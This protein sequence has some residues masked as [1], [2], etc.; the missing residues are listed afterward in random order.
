MYG[1]YLN[2][3][4]TLPSNNFRQIWPQD[5]HGRPGPEFQAVSRTTLGDGAGLPSR[6]GVCGVAPGLVG[7]GV[8]GHTAV[9]GGERSAREVRGDVGVTLWGLGTPLLAGFTRRRGGDR[10][11]VGELVDRVETW[12]LAAHDLRCSPSDWN[13]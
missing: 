12:R 2:A 8:F 11:H 10:A 1:A 9:V 5:I 3:L 7:R 6:H 13:Q 4:Y